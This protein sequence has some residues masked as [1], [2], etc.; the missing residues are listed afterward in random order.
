MTEEQKICPFMNNH[1]LPDFIFCQQEKCMAWVPDEIILENEV[2][3]GW[4][5]LIERG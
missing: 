3:N 1:S 4:C 5:K 2:R